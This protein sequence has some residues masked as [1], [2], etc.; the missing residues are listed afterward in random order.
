MASVNGIEMYYE[1][2]GEG[3][4]LVLLHGFTG[5]GQAWQ[6]FITD[7]AQEYQLIIPDLRGHGRSTNPTNQFTHRQA[8]LDIFALLDQL[9]IDSFAAMGISSGGMTLIHMAT[10]QSARVEAI[11][12]IGTTIYYPNQAR[13]VQRE[14][15]V[16]NEGWDWEVLRQRHVYG[17]G[18]I[19]ALLNRFLSFADSYDDMN[20]TPPYLSTITAQTLIVHGDRD[21]FFPVSIPVEMY[22]AIPNAYL[23]IVPNGDHVPIMDER[24]AAF[25]R[26]ALEFL[27]GEWA[28]E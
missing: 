26:T 20:F 10:Q 15:T 19:K 24:S 23:W 16:E 6:P 28:I 2:H 11:V 7:F 21:M 9:E 8:A 3:T 25:T 5:S 14:S 18:Q 27:R 13:A 4:P 17:D 12:L 1:L 22:S